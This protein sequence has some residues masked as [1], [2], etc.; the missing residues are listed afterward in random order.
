VVVAP[1]GF[2]GAEQRAVGG[3]TDVAGEGGLQPARERPAVDGADDRLRDPVQP[4]GQAAEADVDDLPDAA[5]ALDDRRDVGLE[6]G[7]C[8][9]GVA[10]AGQDR[11]VDRVVVAE[12]RPGPAEQLVQ[13]RVDGVLGLWAVEGQPGDPVVLLV[14]QLGHGSP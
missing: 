14:D 12:V 4:A 10:A 8:A 9:E 7:A 2:E 11:H 6:V 3:D 13:L 5:L 1:T